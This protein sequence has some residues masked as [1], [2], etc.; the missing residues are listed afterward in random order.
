MSRRDKLAEALGEEL[1]GIVELTRE[2]DQFLYL[3]AQDGGACLIDLDAILEAVDE[4][5]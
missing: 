1:E 2:D 4:A 3:N 5:P